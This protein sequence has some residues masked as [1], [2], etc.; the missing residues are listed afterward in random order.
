M[1]TAAAT[2]TAALRNRKD[3]LFAL[4]PAGNGLDPFGFTRIGSK[5]GSE[6]GFVTIAG[7]VRMLRPLEAQKSFGEVNQFLVAHGAS[8]VLARRPERWIKVMS[9]FSADESGWVS[10]LATV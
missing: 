3:A 4:F 2:Y 8:C 6:D 7:I 10:G 1:S 9:V 5:F